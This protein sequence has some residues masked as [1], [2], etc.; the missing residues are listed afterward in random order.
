MI[1]RLFDLSRQADV[2]HSPEGG[3]GDDALFNAHWRRPG[4]IPHQRPTLGS[5]IESSTAYYLRTS[6]VAAIAH[7]VLQDWS[8]SGQ[9]ATRWV[10]S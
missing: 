4:A 9:P 5:R 3:T 2:P 10:A 7:C 8:L 1:E 6:D